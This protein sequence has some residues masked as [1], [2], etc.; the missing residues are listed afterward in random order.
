MFFALLTVLN[1][2]VALTATQSINMSLDNKSLHKDFSISCNDF[3]QAFHKEL[4]ITSEGNIVTSPFSIHM[5]LSLLSHGAES[6]TLD[7]MT[8]G[9]CHRNKDSIKEGY[10]TLIALLNELTNVKLYIANAMYIQDGFELQTEFLA[11]GSDVYKSSISKLDF[12]HNID[13]AEKINAWVKKATNDK[14]SNLVS[15]DDFD[16]DMKLVMVNAIYFNGVW[17]HKFDPKNTEKKTFHVTK[18]ESKFVSM[19]FSKRKYDYGELPTMGS[20]FIE[21]PYMNKDIVM[22]IILPTEKDGLLNLQNN[23]SWEVLANAERSHNEIEL[24]LPKFKIEFTVDLENI[25]RKLGLNTIFED[26]ANFSG[27]SSIPLKVSKVLHKAVIEVHEEGTEAAAATAV[28][29]RLRRMILMPE[30][31][32]V[33]RPFMF[34][35]EYKPN[36]VPLFIGSVKDITVSPE[37]DEL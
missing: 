2:F 14:I 19:M 13:A 32:L 16:E 7:E 22:T 6:E 31:F 26:N 33:D 20:R 34:V 37:R 12:K 3:T 10:A 29:M 24:F 28:Q 36:K 8:V 23:F 18:T 5:I 9:L 25:L 27:I 4:S 30:Q 11:V 17:L 1:T 35:I 21:I 15:S